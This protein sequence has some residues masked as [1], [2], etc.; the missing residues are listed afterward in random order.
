MKKELIIFDMDGLMFDT[1]RI[2]YK[3]WQESA[4]AYGYT[5]SWEIYKQIVARNNRYIEKVL[6]SILGEVLPYEAICEKK[7][8][9]SD[10]IIEEEGL[11]K[12]EGL[13]ELLDYLDDKGIKKA[14]ATSSMREKAMR[15]LE[16]GGI[17]ERFDWII[18]GNEVE[19]SKPN[20]EIFLKVAYQL[21]IAPEACIVLED[22]R[23][24]IQAAKAA[25]MTGIFVPDLVA[26]DEEILSNASQEVA[27]LKE[28]IALLENNLL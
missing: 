27:S 3:A 23:L 25:G 24:G 21:G 7:R 20:P 2:Y 4:A 19:E 5:I 13:M 10:Q 15:Y 11:S 22:S 9:I 18:C 6:K 1:E 28:V 8:A 16:L 26:A 17:K 12:K 14:V